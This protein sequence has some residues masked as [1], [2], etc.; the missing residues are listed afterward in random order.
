M[1]LRAEQSNGRALAW[2]NEHG[3]GK[4]VMHFQSPPHVKME[5]YFSGADVSSKGRMPMN[6]WIHVMHTYQQGDSRILRERSAQQYFENAGCPAG[7][8]SPARLFIGGWYHNYDFTGDIDEVRI[9]NVTRPA[10][11]IKLQ[12]ENQKAQQTLTGP[13]VQPGDTF[14]VSAGTAA[15]LEERARPSPRRRAAHRKCHG[16]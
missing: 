9:S 7:H 12:H 4:V 15:V 3:Q 2:G 16:F 5:C 14:A 1:W 13:V 6:E 11:W 10:E 8:Q